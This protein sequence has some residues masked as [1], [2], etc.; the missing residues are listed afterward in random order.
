MLIEKPEKDMLLSQTSIPDVFFTEYL[1]LAK[2]DYVKVYLYMLFLSK[3]D[4]DI[5]ISDLHKKLSVPIDTISE[6]ISFW[7][8]QGIFIKK[9]NGYIIKDLQQI[10]LNKLY[11][12]KVVI[13][14]ED[15]ENNKKNQYRFNA[16]E[17]INNS[18]FQG[19]M[20]PA[21]YN[22]INLWFTKYQ[23]D[24]EVMLALFKYCFD[25]SALHKNYIK[26]VAEGWQSNNI[27]TFTDLDNYFQKQEKMNLLKKSIAKKLRISRPLTEYEEGYIEK[28]HIEFNYDMDIIEIALKKTTATSK[29]NFN[30]INTILTSWNENGLKTREQI[31]EFIEKNKNKPKSSTSQA[32]KGPSYANYEQR[33]YE[34]LDFLYSNF[35]PENKK[36]SK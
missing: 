7:E 11:S 14:A 23:F 30:Y 25:K 6:A 21:W 36:N 27:K 20:S 35:K 29:P 28:W 12:P 13:S 10:E 31:E 17:N 22:D 8:Q 16:I 34:D 26:K 15:S 5:S 1:C 3:H 19:I 18:F 33:K 24:E 2:G 4:K 9:P 32:K